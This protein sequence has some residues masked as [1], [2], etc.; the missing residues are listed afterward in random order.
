LIWQIYN[1]NSLIVEMVV[2]IILKFS[3]GMNIKKSLLISLYRSNSSQSGFAM[4]LALGLGLVMMIVSASTIARSQSDRTTTNFQKEAN[5]ALSISEAGAVRVQSFLDRYKL[6]ANKNLDRWVDTL[7]TL[8]EFQ[9]NCNSIDIAIAKQQSQLFKDRDWIRLDK[10]NP[11]K[12][13][14]RII[15]YQYQAG[16][17]TLTV[18][19]SIDAY[20]TS[21]HSSTSILKLVIPIESEIAK[22]PPPA[23]WAATFKTNPKQQIRGQIRGVICP[24]PTSKDPDGITGIDRTNITQ[25]DGKVTGKIIADPFISIPP[26]KDAPNIAA[27]IPA[28]TTSIRF[29]LNASDLPDENGEYNYLV[30]IDDPTSKYSIKLQDSNRIQID[31][32]PKHKINLY[33]KGNI[34]LAGSQTISVNSST[35]PNLRIY[36]SNKTTKFNIKNNA[37]ITAFIH[38]PFAVAKNIKSTTT[39][40]GGNI[41]GGIWVKSWD[42][43]TSQGEISIIQS[44]TWKDLGIEADAQPPQL[45]PVSHW[46]RV[47]GN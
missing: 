47:E 23:L 16:V 24:Q 9:R 42:S 21:E 2:D 40:S 32:A 26:P 14:Y 34:D 35:Q 5:R 46:R 44:G 39:I 20:N 7:N 29:P 31:I 33:L 11:N 6:L 4:P 10:N 43:A 25:I 3:F 37:S 41:T 13:R 1:D 19:G 28:I 8:P 22:I 30:D 27:R 18:A 15:D 17:G 12:G 45:N 38:T 36:G